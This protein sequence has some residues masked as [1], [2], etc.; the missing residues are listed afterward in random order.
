MVDLFVRCRPV[1]EQERI[2][3]KKLCMKDKDAHG[4]FWDQNPSFAS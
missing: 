1:L 4:L 3:K 2:K